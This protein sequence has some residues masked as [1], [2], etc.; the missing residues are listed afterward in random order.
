MSLNFYLCF[1]NNKLT[2]SDLPWS[3]YVQPGHPFVQPG[4]TSV[5]GGQYLSTLGFLVLYNIILIY[6]LDLFADDSVA[7]KNCYYLINERN[8]I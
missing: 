8:I 3:Y 5:Q 4:H 2:F 6:N 1:L 7:I